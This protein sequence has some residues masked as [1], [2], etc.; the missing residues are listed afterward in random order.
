MTARSIALALVATTVLSASASE[1]RGTVSLRQALALALE[2][3]PDLAAFSSDMRAADAHILQARLIPNPELEMTSENVAGSGSFANARR[4][5]NTL[6]L[7]QLIELGGKRSARVRE[8]RFGRELAQFDYETKKREVFLQ[9]AEHF[10]D[11]LAAQR[12]VALNEELVS[13]ANGFIPA[14][15]RRAE[16]GK[17]SD[18][19]KTRFEIATGSARIDLENSKRDLLAMRQ[20]LAAQWGSMNPQ[21]SSVVGDL[22]ATPT[23]P[24]F[25]ALARKLPS[26]PRLARFGAEAAKREAAL[27][28]EKAAAIPD[29][30]LRAGARQLNET[31]DGTAV[32]GL[33]LP[34]PLWN[35][36][37]GNIKAAR[38]QI[39]RAGAERATAATLLMTEASDAYQ[40]MARARTTIMTLRES[41]L[42]A[43]DRTLQATAEGYE[44][45]RLSYFEVL[46]ARR[47]IGGARLQYIQA[48]ADYHKAL[49][50]IEALTAAS[51]PHDLP[52]LHE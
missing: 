9:T 4:S 8:A 20:R 14:L 43:A 51:R 31:K 15:E 29:L 13:L 44:R 1:P 46:D 35:R 42:P 33:S 16:A 2:H 6:L 26:N 23:P 41:I 49:H 21:F 17:A 25:D 37:Q 3:N 24:S 40:N 7:G 5:E 50:T 19:E 39:V 10:V 30:T 34:L 22:D 12:R 45:G 47:T 36:N 18:L 38:E 28:R 32:V 27:A 52:S 48:L 11:L